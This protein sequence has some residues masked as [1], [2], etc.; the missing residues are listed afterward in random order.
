MSHRVPNDSERV[1]VN[2][3][4]ELAFWCRE[5]Q[6]DAATLRDAVSA[7]GVEVANVRMHLG[8]TR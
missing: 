3:D 1:N 7:V 8:Q 4:V 2:D 5:L 6:T